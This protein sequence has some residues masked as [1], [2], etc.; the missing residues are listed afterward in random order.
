MDIAGRVRIASVGRQAA[1]AE[2]AVAARG[3]EHT[4]A[5]APPQVSGMNGLGNNIDNWLRD[6]EA[7]RQG[8]E[9]ILREVPG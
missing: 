7:N 8:P 9:S 3:R 1:W 6:E 4:L 5:V 2:L